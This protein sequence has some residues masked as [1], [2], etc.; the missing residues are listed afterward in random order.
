MSQVVNADGASDARLRHGEGQGRARRRLIHLREEQPALR[1]AH[2][3]QSF[4]R[5]LGQRQLSLE[6]Q[7]GQTPSFGGG[8]RVFG[9]A[10]AT[11]APT[12]KATPHPPATKTK[13]ERSDRDGMLVNAWAENPRASLV[14]RNALRPREY[15]VFSRIVE[16][17]GTADVVG[18][19][20]N[21]DFHR[22]AP[23]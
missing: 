3:V 13:D 19:E 20:N 18:A 12:T 6:L 21:N 1:G 9:I 4:T 2:E 15:G 17:R 10:N 23:K 22:H 11:T 7:I 8:A 14:R 16:R 5:R